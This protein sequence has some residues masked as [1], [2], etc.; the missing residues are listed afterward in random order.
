MEERVSGF[1]GRGSWADVVDHG[2]RITRALR[3]AGVDETALT[4][5]EGWR[6]KAEDRLEAEVSERTVEEATLD[7]GPG[8]RAGQPP[9]EDLERASERAVE[10]IETADGDGPG[11]VV[12]KWAE[13]LEHLLR[14]ADTTARRAVRTVESTVYEEVMTRFTPYYFDDEPV[15]ATLRRTTRL[16]DG[17]EFVFE[18]TVSDDDLRAEL[19]RRL[20]AGDGTDGADGG[21]P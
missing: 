12:E 4:A 16:E 17:D 1:R 5:W 2:D 15:S 20:D 7:E 8:E 13:S 19:S 11:D 3:A 6:P 9:S 18:V 10:S 21:D 14:A